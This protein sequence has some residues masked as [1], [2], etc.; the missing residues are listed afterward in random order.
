MKMMN[1]IYELCNR[2]TSMYKCE[3]NTITMN[4]DTYRRLEAEA[5]SYRAFEMKKYMEPVVYGMDIHIDDDLRDCH[6]RLNN[7]EIDYKGH[8]H[9]RYSMTFEVP[10]P[11]NIKRNKLPDKYIINKGATILFW[12]DDTKTIIKRTEE[13]EHNKRLAFLTAYF[14][15]HCGLSKNQA[16]KYLDSL[17]DEDELKILEYAKS[18]ELNDVLSNIRNNLGNVFIGMGRSMIDDPQ[19]THNRT[20]LNEEEQK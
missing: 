10:L 3:P 19:L 20:Q 2:F 4:Y 16:N 5:H 9:H 7:T 17:M 8:A 14:Q 13:D 11:I 12:E 15:K 1:S 6:L 18:G